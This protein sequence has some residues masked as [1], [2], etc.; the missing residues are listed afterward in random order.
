MVNMFV[1]RFS[2]HGFNDERDVVM[3]VTIKMTSSNTAFIALLSDDNVLPHL[4][5]QSHLIEQLA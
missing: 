3:N 4:V 5:A 1:M 2:A